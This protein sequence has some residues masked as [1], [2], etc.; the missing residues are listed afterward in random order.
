MLVAELQLDEGDVHAELELQVDLHLS[1]AGVLRA[2]LQDQG[3]A[4]QAI[5]SPADLGRAKALFVGNSLR[6]L[7]TARLA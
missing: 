1:P 5:L 6:G 2:E 7:I 4:R 3:Q